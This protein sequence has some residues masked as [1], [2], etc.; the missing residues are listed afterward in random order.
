MKVSEIQKRLVQ[1]EMRQQHPDPVAACLDC[2]DDSQ[3]DALREFCLL[4]DSGFSK[5]EIPAMMGPRW[6]VV[7]EAEAA[8][9]ER[10][11][12]LLKGKPCQ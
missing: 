6:A 1:L 9:N 3:L 8:M 12:A 5:D 7:V 4:H 2:L 10:Y 11:N